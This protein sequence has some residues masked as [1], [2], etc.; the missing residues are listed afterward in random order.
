MTTTSSSPTA[1]A[2]V[3]RAKTASLPRA[4]PRRGVVVT[5]GSV[6]VVAVLVVWSVFVG[7][8]DFTRSQVIE[9]ILGG[10]ESTRDILIREFRL[11]RTVLALV[12]GAALGVAGT[13]MQAL[14]RNPLA[15]PGILGVNAGAYLAVVLA[16]TSMG[17][18][19]GFGHVSIALG[20]ALVAAVVVW[21]IGST[22]PAA[23]TP[24]KLVLTGV[25]LGSVLTGVAYAI[26]LLN[27]AVFD[28]VRFWNA[29]SL[30]GRTFQDLWAVLPFIGVGLVIAMLLPRALNALG[31]G[32]DVAVALGSRPAITRIVGLVAVTLLC[33]A[34]TAVAGPLSFIGL[35]APHALRSLVGP[36][37]RWLVPLSIVGAAALM[38]AADILAR[39]VTSAELPVGVVTAFI[40]AP[41]L[42]ALAR[43]KSSRST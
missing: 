24:T 41:V 1:S 34:A 17:P 36:D 19:L 2:A 30:Q 11:A 39:V 32:D 3:R 14:A 25:A 10:G 42:V 37:H 29:G 38:L 9:A 33:G 7:S 26:S 20:G 43:R 40:G 4:T 6:L 12:V 13:L 8:G 22:G 18:I 5:V 15:D 27:P 28:R 21:V 16:A 35:L 23:G 31:L